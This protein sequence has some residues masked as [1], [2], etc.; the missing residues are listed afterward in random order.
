VVVVQALMSAPQARVEQEQQ[1]STA[2]MGTRLAQPRTGHR[3][4]AVARARL[5]ATGLQVSLAMVG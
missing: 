5:A 2:V 3:E 4:L 1:V